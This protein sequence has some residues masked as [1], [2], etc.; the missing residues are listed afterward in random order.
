[1][2]VQIIRAKVSD[3]GAVDGTFN[4]WSKEL[5]PGAKGWLGT[6]GGVTDD[7]QLFIMVRFDSPEAARANSERPEQDRFWSETSKQFDGQAIFQESTDVTVDA[8]GDLDSAGFV[9]VMTGQVSDPD[10]AK[11]IMAEQPDMRALRPDVLGNVSIGHEDG[12]WTMVIY[13]TSEA[14]AREGEAKQMPP[15]AL[16][17]MEQM[18]SLSVGQPEFLDLR[19]PWLASPE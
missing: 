19:T 1:M 18:Q 7:G 9:Q 8:V 15:E 10:R 5:A 2:F 4:R 3:P 6:T 12:K 17:A 16:E 11:Q 13:F 14:Q